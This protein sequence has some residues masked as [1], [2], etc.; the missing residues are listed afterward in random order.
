[1]DAIY[2]FVIAEVT[3]GTGNIFFHPY[4]SYNA[5]K[6]VWLYGDAAGAKDSLI[7]PIKI[8]S[9]RFTMFT[10]PTFTDIALVLSV[11]GYIE[12]YDQ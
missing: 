7:F 2:M 8:V 11:K 5:G 1:M 6:R 3:T 12:F 10:G 4:E 9:Q